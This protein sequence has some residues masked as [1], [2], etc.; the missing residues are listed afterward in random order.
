MTVLFPAFPQTSPFR[1]FTAADGLPENRVMHMYEDSYGFLW[2]FSRNGI[3]R[4]D[5]REVISFTFENKQQGI[6]P[7][8]ITEDDSGSIWITTKDGLAVFDGKNFVPYQLPADRS[9][10]E[11]HYELANYAPGSFYLVAKDSTG[12]NC[13]VSFSEGSYKTVELSD[14]LFDHGTVSSLT[15]SR[16]YGGLYFNLDLEAH[17][18][19]NDTIYDVDLPKGL[20]Y[21]GSGAEL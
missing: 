4:T 13:L 2:C 3:S 7:Y 18:L 1:K 9:Y 17:M 10:P 6:A 21:M 14:T 19:R 12:M 11:I 20:A 8:M 16:R 15:Y 5:G